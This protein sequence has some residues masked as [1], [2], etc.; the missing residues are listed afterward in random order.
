MAHEV[1]TERLDL[2]ALAS[3]I[4]AQ[5]VL[6]E[7]LTGMVDD[8][9]DK[10]IRDRGLDRVARKA[11]LFGEPIR[12]PDQERIDMTRA[13]LMG[14]MKLGI[15]GA[16]LTDA[17]AR[18]IREA[19]RKALS[20]GTDS[21]GG[22]LTPSEHRADIIQRL[23]E[24]S[25]LFPYVRKVPVI[26]DGG[27]YPKL[28]TD[29][30]ITW[31]TAENTALSE[32]DPAYTQLTYSISKATAITYI[33]R[34]LVAD[35]NPAIVDHVT[36]L[37]SEAM[38]AERDKMITK[39][40]GSS[41]PEG[42]VSAT[43]ISAVS[44]CSGALS[45]PKLV[46]LKFGL[47]RK[48][49]KNARFI[50][51]STTL[52]WVHELTDSNGRPVFTDAITRDDYPRILG[53]EYSVQ[54]DIDEGLIVYGDLSQYYWFDRQQMLIETTTTGGD[55]FKK[56]QLAI[57]VVERCDGKTALGEAFKKSGAF[58]VPS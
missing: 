31:G 40:T 56:H 1:R 49:Q 6:P 7:T 4:A 9:V 34:E 28:D 52:Q 5:I 17:Q 29:V 15:P 3:R 21:A 54:D 58:T 27:D 26:S 10:A 24:L 57:K 53:K 22:Y 37:F 13:F 36:Q 33:S 30:S 20:E 11:G 42:L 46:R 41:Q 19:R 25:E 47:V 8:A 35:S 18:A 32:T 55:T 43:G 16:E 23:P 48:Y 14:V 51:N 50:L 38:A 39:G 45:Y 12:S 2:D 44:G